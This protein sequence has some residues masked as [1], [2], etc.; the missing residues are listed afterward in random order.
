MG[1]C[2][3]TVDVWDALQSDRPYRNAW[4]E[5]R[6]REYLREQSGKHFDPR[7]VEVFLKEVA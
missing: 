7:V 4:E 3:A 2:N 1:C 5:E 6:V